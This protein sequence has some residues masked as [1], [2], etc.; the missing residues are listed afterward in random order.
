[1]KNH[2]LDQRIKINIKQLSI[3]EKKIADYFV[4]DDGTLANQTLEQISEYIKVSKSSIF[5]FVKKL[6]YNGFQ[7]FKIDIAKHSD[8]EPSFEEM[9]FISGFDTLS[10]NDSNQTI[11]T[12][13]LQANIYS[14]SNSLNFLT[15][16]KL[17][18]VLQIINSSETLHF[19]GQGGS[20]IV[21]YDSFHKFIR[22]KYRCNYIA[23]YHMQLSFATKLN[24]KDCV[25][26]FSHSGQTIESINLAQLVKKSSAQL[27]VFTGNNRSELL[28]Y[29]DE[30]IIILTEE[31]IFRTESLISR[32]SY[33]TAVDILY[34]IVMFKD[35]EE[36]INSLNKIRS[37]VK[38][39]K[40]ISTQKEPK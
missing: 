23:D 25:F 6:G 20:S 4:N 10:P 5:Q 16:E 19:F 8:Y 28:K 3:T 11:A 21:A 12:K 37:S 38:S 1:M 13:V 9:K 31:T 26:I 33:L 2:Y 14:L 36:N 35:Y 32:I 24:E 18:N 30:S 39:S 27:I 34:M 40:R 7:S 17:D 29:S 22:T 15:H